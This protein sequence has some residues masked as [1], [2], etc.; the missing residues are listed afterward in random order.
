M[1]LCQLIAARSIHVA[2]PHARHFAER[3]LSAGCETSDVWAPRGVIC[4]QRNAIC[5]P[6]RRRWHAG[7]KQISSKLVKTDD[8]LPDCM[9]SFQG[10][11]TPSS[12]IN[13]GAEEGGSRQRLY[14]REEAK[15][16]RYYEIQSGYYEVPNYPSF[17]SWRFLFL[18]VDRTFCSWNGVNI[19]LFLHLNIPSQ[20]HPVPCQRLLGAWI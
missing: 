14:Q 5:C 1:G 3:K 17:I 6:K 16:G 9:L 8:P 2:N 13:I 10:K 19:W 4:R 15:G 18:W 7:G 12:V 20:C 11:P